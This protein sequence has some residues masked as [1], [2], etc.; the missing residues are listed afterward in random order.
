[1]YNKIEVTAIQRDKEHYFRHQTVGYG[2]PLMRN[3]VWLDWVSQE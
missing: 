2:L 1:M 3:L